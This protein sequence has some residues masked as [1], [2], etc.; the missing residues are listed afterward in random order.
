MNDTDKRV[1]NIDEINDGQF[2]RVHIRSE[3]QGWVV[4]AFDAER[5]S[6]SLLVLRKDGV[7]G[8]YWRI[9]MEVIDA[10]GQ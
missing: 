9:R 4:G 10:I 8:N 1:V 2:L 5:S 6:E 3:E 7:R